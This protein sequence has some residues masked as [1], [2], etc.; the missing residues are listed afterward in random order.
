MTP[1]K[2]AKFNSAL[3][4]HCSMIVQKYL[5]ILKMY[6]WWKSTIFLCKGKGCFKH[7]ESVKQNGP[8]LQESMIVDLSP[9]MLTFLETRV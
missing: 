2:Q 1:E 6:G 7:P 9:T 3:P 8:I 4:D 5:G